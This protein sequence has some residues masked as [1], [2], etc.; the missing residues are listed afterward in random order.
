MR[1]CLFFYF[2]LDFNSDL[3]K[4]KCES[5]EIYNFENQKCEIPSDC[6]NDVILTEKLEMRKRNTHNYKG[7]KIMRILK[8]KSKIDI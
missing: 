4:Q 3:C 2:Y 1:I 7:K 6:L 8:K 5:D